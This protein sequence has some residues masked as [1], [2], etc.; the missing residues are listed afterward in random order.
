MSRILICTTPVPGHVAPVSVLAR[1]LVERG[2]EVVWH[3]GAAF[4]AQVEA[5]G[6]RHVP[7]SH[8]GD[9][10]TTSTP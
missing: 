2:N 6:A 4:A 5:T 7:I 9:W 8:D 1:R 10:S 3:T